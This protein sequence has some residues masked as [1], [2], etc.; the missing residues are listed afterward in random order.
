MSKIFAFFLLASTSLPLLGQTA[1]EIMASVRQVAALQADADLRGVMK[2]GRKK[3]PLSMFLRGKEI[4]FKIDE[5]KE[6]F[7]L[8]LN[9]HN[10]E[11]FDTTGGQA[12]PF[13]SEKI[14]R[15]IAGTDVSYEDLA[16][17]F[18]YWPKPKIAGEDSIKA[19]ACWRIHLVNPEATGRY[20]EISVWVSKKQ[21]ALMRI[22]G[23]GPR[24]AAVAL[25]QFEVLDIMRR[26]KVWT[27]RKLKVSAFKESGK[28]E[29]TTYIDFGKK[30]RL[31]KR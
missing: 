24:P 27:V 19:Q 17:K 15:D 16:M 1:E 4:H 12:R 2:A 22:I 3:V 13:A 31:R 10:Q 8:R 9:P 26:G 29:G 21:R 5:G 18:L 11:L 7:A 25:K 23:Y 14:S 20:R 6:S 30:K 28:K